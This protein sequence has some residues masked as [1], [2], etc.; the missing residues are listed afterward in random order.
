MHMII[1]DNISKKVREIE[2]KRKISRTWA[3]T[4]KY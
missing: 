4:E 2:Y 1:I 3:K